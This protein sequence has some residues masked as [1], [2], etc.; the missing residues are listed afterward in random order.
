MVEHPA[1][2]P[3]PQLPGAPPNNGP[4]IER[5]KILGIS[6]LTMTAVALAV[7]T[8]VTLRLYRTAL[9]QHRGQLI[10][11]ARSQAR[12]LEAVARFDAEHSAEDVGGAFAATIGQMRDAQA[13]FV[14][15]GETGEFDLARR[16]GDQMVFL[17]SHRRIVLESSDT[18]SFSSE[19]AEP[20]RRALSG[21][22]GALVG[23]DH[24][25]QV[26]LA[27]YEPVAVLD[28]GIVAKID[29]AEIRAPFVRTSRIAA[30]GAV[31][32]IALGGALILLSINPVIKRAEDS[33]KALEDSR[34]SLRNLAAKLDA[35][36]E[37]ERALIMREMHDELGQL[38]TGLRM[39][40]SWLVG[41]HTND[42]DALDRL[43]SMISVVDTSAD[44]VRRIAQRQRPAILDDLGLE[45]AVEWHA[46]ELKKQTGLSVTL[47]LSGGELSLD[48]DGTTTVFRIFQEAINNVVRHAEATRVY[49]G[50]R[51]DPG[52]LTLVVRDDGKGISGDALASTESLGLIG[53][54]ERA[55]TLGAQVTINSLPGDGTEI[56][57]T[58]PMASDTVGV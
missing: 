36:R 50:L 24:H 23:L 39:G 31:L 29:L 5:R 34:Q 38:L 1:A 18:I 8:L 44:T 52:Q 17:L 16:E 33:T 25:R 13:S 14:G 27:A 43:E 12:L 10:T 49:I 47:D 2:P 57:L 56:V 3:H 32:I 4:A 41:K 26:V 51:T 37:D 11:I 46:R 58:M 35:V 48:T 19:L 9:E 20:M 42:A 28:L 6:I 45:A 7:G 55:R 54:R 15:F 53:M 21:E 22:S 30:V 40:L